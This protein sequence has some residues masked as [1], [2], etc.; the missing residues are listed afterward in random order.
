MFGLL[1][2]PEG[3]PACVFLGV[4]S[5]FGRRLIPYTREP[6]SPVSFTDCYVLRCRLTIFNLCLLGVVLQ[7]A[8]SADIGGRRRPVVRELTQDENK[9]GANT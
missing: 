4:F 8:P 5:P 3:P 7:D 6:V 1:L 9:I 2:P